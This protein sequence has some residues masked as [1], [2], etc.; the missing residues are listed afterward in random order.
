LE[1]VLVLARYVELL[2]D[3]RLFIPS[4]TNLGDFQHLQRKVNPETTQRE[5]AEEGEWVWV[6]TPQVKGE[7]VRFKV[8]FTLNLDPRVVHAQ[9]GWWFPEK[10]SPGPWLL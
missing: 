2:D 7:R 10:P 1:R 3:R 9:P 6:Q 4:R 8:K 5:D